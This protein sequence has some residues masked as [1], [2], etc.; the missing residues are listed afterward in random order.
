MLRDKEGAVAFGSALDRKLF[1]LHVPPNRSGNEHR[2]R[3]APHLGPGTYNNHEMSN[4]V[5]E[6]ENRISSNK[7]Y[8]LGARTARRFP[9]V[10]RAKAVPGPGSYQHRSCLTIGK[11]S[12]KP[13]GAASTRFPE[14]SQGRAQ[15]P[16]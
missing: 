14:I 4:F 13:F 16:G 6:A 1:P 8:S 9:G 15:L 11:P 10:K 5:Y 7:G 12:A 3:G 2:L